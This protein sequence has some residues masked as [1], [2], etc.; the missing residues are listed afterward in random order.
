[1]TVLHFRP[2]AAPHRSF[3]LQDI[4]AAPASAP[5]AED[6][7]TDIAII[8][9]GYLGLWTALRLKAAA[10]ALSVTILEADL[11]GSGASGR[12]GGQVHS[13]WAEIDLLTRLVGPEAESLA[14]ATCDAI[15]ELA[16]LQASG[17]IEMD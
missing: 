4:G 1:M 10:P 15:E 6:I 12:N 7:A 14:R 17:R 3:W 11:C 2:L 5:L 9:G 8:G 13:W 16:A